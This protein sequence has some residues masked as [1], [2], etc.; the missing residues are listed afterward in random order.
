MATLDEIRAQGLGNLIKAGEAL[1]DPT[2]VKPL[3]LESVTPISAAEQ[4]AS[5][6]AQ[7]SISGMP[8]YLGQGVGALGQAANTAQQAMTTSLAGSQMYD[9]NS[10]Q[11][12]MNPYQQDVID[13]YTSEMNRQFGIQGQT[14]N[15]QALQAGAFGGSRQGVFDAEASRGFNQQLGQ[16]ISQLLN[17]GYGEAQKQAQNAF[18]Q[19][20]QRMQQAGQ[21]QLGAGQL[22]QGIGQLYGQFAPTSAQALGTNVETLGK[23][24]AQER[25]I[26]Q[27]EQAVQ[28]ANLM[29]QYQQPYQNL[30]FQSGLVGGVPS[31]QYDSVQSNPFMT[32]ISAL[33]GNQGLFGS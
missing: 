2:K 22:Q 9:P 28:Y 20:Q 15:A 26:G 30:S 32:G 19:Q 6:L 5:N 13:A 31:Q 12:F 3:P 1:T 25:G 27:Q 33:L 10:Y 4:Q 16:G 11:N 29:R 14:R 7:S 8:D 18:Q 17:T 24:G 21:N 23:I